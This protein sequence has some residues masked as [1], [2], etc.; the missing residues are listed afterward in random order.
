MVVVQENAAP[1]DPNQP[2]RALVPGNGVEL[3]I[4]DMT[5]SFQSYKTLEAA[6]FPLSAFEDAKFM[7]IAGPIM[8]DHSQKRSSSSA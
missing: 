7:P 5:K 6:G 8:P 3:V 1:N 2:W 4:K